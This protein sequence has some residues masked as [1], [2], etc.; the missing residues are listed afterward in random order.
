MPAPKGELG[1]TKEFTVAALENRDN[2]LNVS[3]DVSQA[4]LTKD[5]GFTDDGVVVGWRVGMQF[6]RAKDLDNTA[7]LDVATVDGHVRE[8]PLKEDWVIKGVIKAMDEKFE[9]KEEEWVA[10]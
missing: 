10:V 2:W 1:T 3:S 8:C 9:N 7:F 4:C 6:V 5:M